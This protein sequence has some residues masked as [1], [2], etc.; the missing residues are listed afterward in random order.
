M[1]QAICFLHC[2]LHEANE[3]YTSAVLE[4]ILPNFLVSRHAFYLIQKGENGY[5]LGVIGSFI[6]LLIDMVRCLD[7]W[8]EEISMTYNDAK[9][10]RECKWVRY[11]HS[12]LFVKFPQG[13]G[14]V[15][16]NL[17]SRGYRILI[18]FLSL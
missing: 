18:F 6:H 17:F 9:V 3:Y 15:S 8:P 10:V 12:G 11:I 2:R 14:C 13:E 4:L 16:S 1:K 7:T 5:I